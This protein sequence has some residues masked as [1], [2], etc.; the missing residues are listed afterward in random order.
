MSRRRPRTAPKLGTVNP[1]R[2]TPSFRER[3]P[4]A[5]KEIPVPRQ[6]EA[7]ILASGGIGGTVRA[8]MLGDYSVL[9][10]REPTGL[11]L[12]IAG[13]DGYPPWDVIAEARARLLPPDLT[14]AMILPPMDQYVNI[15]E[16][17]FHLWQIEAP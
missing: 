15:H 14:F 4:L 6:T 12:S 11:H 9:V 3:P 13:R 5:L 2:R 17:C 16:N 1:H 7:H 10:S 8:Y